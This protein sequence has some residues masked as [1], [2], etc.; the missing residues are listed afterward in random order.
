M[1]KR[2]G[3]YRI[4]VGEHQVRRPVGRPRRK[5]KNNIK[6]DYKE[7]NKGV[8]WIGVAEDWDKWQSVVKTGMCHR[9]T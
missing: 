9:F 4:V 6:T 1:G 5:W 3:A 8:K 7:K 2:G